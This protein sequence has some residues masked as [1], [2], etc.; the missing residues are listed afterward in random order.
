MSG[1][2]CFFFV[3]VWSWNKALIDALN[4]SQFTTTKE[5]LIEQITV[6]SNDFFA[7]SVVCV[8][9]L[10][11]WRPN[12]KPVILHEVFTTFLSNCWSDCEKIGC[13]FFIRRFIK[14]ILSRYFWM[15]IRFLCWNIYSTHTI[16]SDIIHS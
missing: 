10:G 3:C 9:Q 6:Q 12:Y 4:D 7:T 16:I 15:H 8:C 11:N 1:E 13:R 14:T 5:S 2:S